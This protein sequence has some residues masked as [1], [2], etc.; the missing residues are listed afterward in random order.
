MEELGRRCQQA[1]P[2]T[3]VVFT[4]HGLCIEGS[5]SLSLA[6]LGAGFVDG[7]N[8]VRIGM[9]FVVDMEL[10]D[11]I[12]S[13]GF[14]L[15]VPVALVG[16]TPDRKPLTVFPLDWGVLVPMYFLGAKWDRPPRVVA[17]C[18]DRSIPRKKLVAFGEA[19]VRAAA[20]LGRR[21]AIVCSADQ[22]H[23]HSAD[24]P[25]G[26]APES[27]PHDKAYCAAI[28]D[29]A[30]ERL[31]YWR[32]DRIEAAL[33]DSYWQTLMLLGALRMTKLQPHFLSYEA[34]TYFG[35]ACAAFEPPLI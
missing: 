29:N 26:F 21:I 16:L 11:G 33:T 1:R 17:A 31:L 28:R 3:V 4:P 12:A 6:Q 10:A 20:R 23:G 18:P 25:Y 2:E 30:L 8:G 24:G 14:R 34:P 32:N 27:L 5:I 19:V 22:G 15:E 13:E 7:E 35:M 9:R